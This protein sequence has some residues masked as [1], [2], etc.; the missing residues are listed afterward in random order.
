MGSGNHDTRTSTPAT[1]VRDNV[2]VTD[3]EPS[4]ELLITVVVAAHDEAAAREAC[5]VLV[6]RLGGRIIDCADCSDEEPG[7]MSVT[8]T[9]VSAERPTGHMSA[10]LA[11]AVRGFLRELGPGYTGKRVSC[12][13]P[14]AWTVLDDPHIVGGLVD[15]GER[16]LVEAWYGGSLARPAS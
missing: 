10:S 11:R 6:E 8:I 4:L 3:P 12:E 16:M 1:P 5:G 9:R 2:A 15:G 7:C 13:P 14:T